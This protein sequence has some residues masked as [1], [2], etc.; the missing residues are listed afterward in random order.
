MTTVNNKALISN[1]RDCAEDETMLF[2]TNGGDKPFCQQGDLNI[3]PMNAHYE[4]TLLADIFLVKDV[5]DIM[6]IW[7]TMDTLE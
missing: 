6:G 5:Q 1:I 7:I 4:P 2:H 3:L